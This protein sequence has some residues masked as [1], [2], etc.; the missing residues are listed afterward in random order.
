MTSREVGA[1]TTVEGAA[2]TRVPEGAGKT[3]ATDATDVT[4]ENGGATTRATG[5]TDVT[6]ENG[7][8]P[9]T[10]VV[11]GRGRILTISVVQQAAVAVTHAGRAAAR[12]RTIIPMMNRR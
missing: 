4:I 10:G 12:T 9:A 1:A 3:A 5:A 7:R 8:G 11:N 2:A 6:T